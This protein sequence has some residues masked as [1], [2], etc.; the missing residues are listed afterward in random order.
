[1]TR[2]DALDLRASSFSI[3][4]KSAERGARHTKTPSRRS[5]Q[6]IDLAGL[7]QP[8]AGWP[9]EK[10]TLGAELRGVAGTVP[11][12]L[13]AVP[14]HIATL[15]GTRWRQ[16]DQLAP[17]RAICGD[18]FAI[19]IENRTL[20]W[21]QAR[22]RIRSPRILRAAAGCAARTC[23]QRYANAR[24]RHH[25]TPTRPSLSR[26]YH[27]LLV[28][29]WIAARPICLDSVTQADAR[30]LPLSLSTAT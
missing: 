27:R 11:A 21:R 4:S 17:V 25:E 29:L 19:N 2:E 3:A 6:G 13:R 5:Q 20:S 18:L 23:E 7:G 22:Q 8:L 14:H 15:M 12:F 28:H 30:L 1:L 9:L 26:H 16:L 24:C 10:L